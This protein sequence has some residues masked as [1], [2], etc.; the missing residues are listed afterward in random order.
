MELLQIINHTVLPVVSVIIPSYN[1][2]DTIARTIESIVNQ[3]SDYFFEIIIGDDF[4]IDSVREVLLDYQKRYPEKISLLFHEKNIGLGANWANCVKMC[5][6]KYIAGCDNDDFWHNPDKLSIQVEFL[7]KNPEYGMVHTDYY[8]LNRINGILTRK[9][10][11]NTSYKDKLI[12]EIFNGNFK[13]CNSSVMYRKSI[14]DEFVPLD[15]YINYQFPLQDW[16]TWICIAKYTKFYCLPVSTTTVGKEMESITRPVNYDIVIKR[17]IKEKF[18]YKY[19]CDKFPEDL[20]YDELSYDLHVNH[21]LL[22]VAFNNKDFAAAK[23]FSNQSK[24]LG[25]KELKNRAANNLVTFHFF[26]ILKKFKRHIA[27][28]KMKFAK[29]WKN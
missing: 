4:S 25:S 14:I 27:F 15:D 17:F 10:V 9:I 7:E 23:K 8:E 12:K 18:V 1:R 6:G 5:R 2:I 26:I 29:S 19:L 13:C 20:H 16:Y 3:V 28:L 21:I 22:N 11:H 24:I